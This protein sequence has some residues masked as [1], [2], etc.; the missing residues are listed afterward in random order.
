MKSFQSVIGTFLIGA[1]LALGAVYSAPSHAVS[2]RSESSARHDVETQRF[3]VAN[4]TCASCPITV[5][6]AMSRVEGV[7][8]VSVDLG[9]KV[10]TVVFDPSK[11]TANDIA[12]ASTN[13]GF[14]ATAIRR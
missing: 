10:A 12:A 2:A 11:T 14:P 8:S 3:S 6:T 1:A 7:Q 9:S 5:R 13:V 4:M